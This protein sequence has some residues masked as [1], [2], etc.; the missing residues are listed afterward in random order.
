MQL[1]FETN[2]AQPA[3]AAIDP[4]AKSDYFGGLYAKQNIVCALL[5]SQ[6]TDGFSIVEIVA[7]TQFDLTKSWME[8]SLA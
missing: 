3:P 2:L 4:R 6:R 5:T 7:E 1:S 8:G